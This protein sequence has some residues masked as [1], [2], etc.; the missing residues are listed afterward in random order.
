MMV[1]KRTLVVVLLLAAALSACA[2]STASPTTPPTE[3]VTPQPTP[4]LA[5]PTS[6]PTP[7]PTVPAIPV[8][9]F[10]AVECL[11]IGLSGD[12]LRAI[13]HPGMSDTSLLPY[14]TRIEIIEGG[15]VDIEYYS[16][17]PALDKVNVKRFTIHDG[18]GDRTVEAVPALKLAMHEYVFVKDDLQVALGIAISADA[19]LATFGTPTSDTT[20][21]GD[22]EDTGP[23]RIREIAF[24]ELSLTIV[25]APD[26]SKPDLWGAWEFV[27]SD[28]GFTGPRGLKVGMTLPELVAYLGTG[29]FHYT[30]DSFSAPGLMVLAARS[31]YEESVDPEVFGPGDHDFEIQFVDGRVA[32]I[33][34]ALILN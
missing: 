15:S 7:E 29:G 24:E 30:L 5:P 18:S 13:C 1:R 9:P 31:P 3:A 34:I 28:P 22:W 17:D 25:Q 11:G 10:A 23:K 8:L 12:S 16:I 19:L 32:T 14:P 21:E 4:S 20:E 26:T 2:T 33:R 6:S 27:V